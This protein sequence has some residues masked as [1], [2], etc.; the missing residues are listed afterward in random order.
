MTDSLTSITENSLIFEDQINTFIISDQ[1]HIF[2]N[3]LITL[4]WRR[5]LDH[6]RE[7]LLEELAHGLSHYHKSIKTHTES[8]QYKKIRLRLVFYC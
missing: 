8:Q 4:F 6:A 3:R 1:A 5:N 2:L 7:D